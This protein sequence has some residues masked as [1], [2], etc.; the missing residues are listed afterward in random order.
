M[1]YIEGKLILHHS[2]NYTV[3]TNEPSYDQ[4]LAINS[5]WAPIANVSLPGTD[6]P[7]DRFVRLSYY[8]STVPDSPDSTLALAV[9]ASMIRAVSVPFKPVSK[10]TP[11]VSPTFWR[12]YADTRDLLYFYENA[13]EPLGSFVD[14][15]A[16]DLGVGG[17]TRV[18]SLNG[19]WTDRVGNVT[20]IMRVAEP[21]EPI[22]VDD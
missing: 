21:F 22:N 10:E 12:T 4:Q 16:L 19:T 18:L 2:R 5:Y 7:A 15:K 17:E 20:A 9:T 14:M 8:A 3:M 13:D 11:N 6:R 1:E